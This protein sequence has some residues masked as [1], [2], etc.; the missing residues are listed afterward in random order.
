MTAEPEFGD[1]ALDYGLLA[2]ILAAGLVYWRYPVALGQPP[3]GSGRRHADRA[4]LASS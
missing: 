1:S 4:R 3:S 2:G